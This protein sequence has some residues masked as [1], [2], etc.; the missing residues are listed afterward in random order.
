MNQT[1]ITNHLGEDR[2]NYYG[3][4]SPPIINS[5]NF[6]FDSV[7]QMRDNMR[8]ELNHSIYSSGCNPTVAILRKK[9]AALAGGEDAL[10]LNSGSTAM[11]TAIL[12]NI[13]YGDH[14]IC[15]DNPYFNTK[16][17]LDGTIKKF[18]VTTSYIDGKDVANFEK[19]IKPNTKLIILESPTSITFE[20]QDIEAV[21][22]LAKANNIITIMDNS[23]A[24][25]IF[26]KPLKLGVDITIHSATKYLAG[27]SDVIAGIIIS[28][29]KYIKKIFQNEF[30]TF[31]G[32]I[33]A[34]TAWLLLRSLRTFSLRMNHISQ[35]TETVI[36][37]LKNHPK[38]KQIY[39]PFDKNNLQYDLAKKQMTKASGLFSLKLKV[40]NAR[41]VERF[42]NALQ[43]FHLAVSWG[44]HESLVFPLCV[45]AA[46]KHE[47]CC[48]FSFD[49]IRFS[50]GLDEPDDLIEDLDRALSI[51]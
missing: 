16:K 11:V 23:Y 34:N 20:M 38:V 19:A 26:Q 45:L 12:S 49:L 30:S 1:Y 28:S 37:W 39:Y 33:S 43:T 31:G 14:I 4:V 25:P 27:H 6:A 46:D 50:I 44:G 41:E 21:V 48:K 35:N 9:I 17:L 18:G 40:E 13:E 24:S 7:N 29:N 5:I 3:A 32:A 8:D 10:I 36:A 47:F 15:V 51:I 22:K 2:E 42:V